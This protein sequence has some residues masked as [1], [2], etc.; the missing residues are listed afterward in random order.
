MK[1]KARFELHCLRFAGLFNLAI[2]IRFAQHA[3]GFT[4]GIGVS[5]IKSFTNSTLSFIGCGEIMGINIRTS[6]RP[7]FHPKG[8]AMIIPSAF[9][10]IVRLANFNV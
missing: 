10:G 2:P 5:Q 1:P 7:K 4:S 8:C 3:P 6:T 9:S